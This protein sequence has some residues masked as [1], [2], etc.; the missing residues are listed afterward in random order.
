MPESQRRLPIPPQPEQKSKEF[1]SVTGEKRLDPYYWLNERENPEVVAYLEAENRYATE[2]L[3]PVAGLE[4]QLLEEM[5]GR[6]K[7]DDN[8]VPY[9]KNGYWYHTKFE[10][11]K[12]YPVYCRRK[13]SPDATE[14]ILID[15]NELA[16][17]HA[18]CQ[19]GGLAVSPD[20]G[21]LAYTVDF[22]GRFLFKA[23]VKNLISG[24]LLSDT[25]DAGGTIVWAND[26]SSV[27]YDTKDPETLR[28]DKVW[29]HVLGDAS[30]KDDLLY[31]EKDDSY[32]VSLSKS[33]SEQFFFISMGYS[34]SVETRY[35]DA[36]NPN[37]PFLV[38]KPR[39]KGKDSYYEVEHWRDSFL[40]RTNLEA[41][42]FRIMQAPVSAPD[43][44]N[45]KELLPHRTDVLV[46]EM[47]VFQD[48]LATLER[49]DGLKQLHVIRMSD[50]NDHYINIGE[51]TYETFFDANPEFRTQTLRYAF[52]SLKTPNTVVDYNM[53]T[54]QSTVRK[55][56]P[57]LGGFDAGNYQTEF[58][59][60]TAR[61]GARI[62]VSLVYKKGLKPDGT[63][64]CLLNG[65][66]AYGFS[67][68]PGFNRDVVSLLDRGFVHAIAHVRGGMEMGYSW[69][70]NGKLLHKMNSFLDFI[71]CARMLCQEKYT[72]ANRL[73]ASGRSAG[74]LLMGGVANMAPDQ[75][76]GIIAGVPF[77]DVLTTM[78]DPSI[79]LTTG[80]Y[81]EWGNPELPEYYEYIR[82]YSPYDNL[83]AQRYPHIL[84]VTSFSDS[85]VQYFE[86]AKYVARLRDLKT[87]DHAV[88]LKTNMTG[89]HGGSSGR[90]ERLKERALEYAWMLGLS[91]DG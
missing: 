32:Y 19:L 20:N 1:T 30:M 12:E 37:G 5:K 81:T 29:R 73:F 39:E 35:L 42:N 36:N 3:A 43:V 60:V 58:I 77:V 44:S 9:F 27:L 59:W 47:M 87:D 89:S 22:T 69:Y 57:V 34:Q 46:D 10:A 52:S 21:L 15:V 82:Q 64:P 56:A 86:P 83:K 6:I 76:K 54:R 80:E 90:F 16:A 25:F 41:P 63:A 11:G 31:E 51:P 88:L 84:V 61:D 40:I 50:L 28:N 53:E 85:Q 55:I 49:K 66:G 75:F 23:F 79:P 48:Y 72:S 14:E 70:E 13:E 18:F 17:G 2:M 62:P 26:N 7:Q 67:Y 4:A 38:V 71:D 65:Y 45:W 24:E 68:D 8:S 74:G 78:S 33:K 91:G